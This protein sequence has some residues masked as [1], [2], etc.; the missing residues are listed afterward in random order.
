MTLQTSVFFKALANQFRK[1]TVNVVIYM[2]IRLRTRL[3]LSLSLYL[4]IRQTVHG[5]NWKGFCEILYDNFY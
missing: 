1:I 2:S 3:S 4:L 5:S